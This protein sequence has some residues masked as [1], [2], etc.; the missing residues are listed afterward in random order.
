MSD[1]SVG[2]VEQEETTD[3]EF[4][5]PMLPGVKLYANVIG[6][7]T[8]ESYDPSDEPGHGPNYVI[9]DRAR[10]DWLIDRLQELREGL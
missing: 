3:S 9:L 4:E 6:G 1:E 5:L 7:I 10:V 8:I 2:T